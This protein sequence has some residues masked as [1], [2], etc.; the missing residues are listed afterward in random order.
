MAQEGPHQGFH[1]ISEIL[2][3]HPVFRGLD[4]ELIDRLAG[5]SQ[6]VHFSAN[7]YLF[8]AGASADT[9]LLLRAG[10]VAL[11]LSMPGRER[12]VVQTLHPGQIVG[13][14][15]LL[16]PYEWRFDARAVSDVRATSVNATCLRGKCDADPSLGY[17]VMQRFLPIIAERLQSTRLR[18]LDLYAPPAQVGRAL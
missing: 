6:N 11:E 14:S 8:K 2:A 13:A 4:A 9:I 15:W 3:S 7:A 17:E 5:C 18:L 16:P 1:S 10:D 12:L